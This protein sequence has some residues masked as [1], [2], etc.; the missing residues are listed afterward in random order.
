MSNKISLKKNFLYNFSLNIINILFPL[1]VSPYVSRIL[2]VSN[3][4]KYSFSLALINWFLIFATFGTTIYGIREISKVREDQKQLNK[5]FSE[6]FVINFITTFITLIVYLLII[7]SIYFNS[8]NKEVL[9]LLIF[10]LSIF[11]NLF[12]IDWLYMGLENFKTIALRSLLIK[13]ISLICIFLFI[14]ERNDY[15]LYALISILAFGFANILNLVYSK[16][17]VKLTLKNLSLKHHIRKLSVFFYSNLVISMYTIFDQ[18]LLGFLSTNRDVGYYSRAKQIYSVSLSVTLS[19]ST[20]LLPKLANLFKNDF[21]KYE[22]TLKKSINYIYIFSVPSVLG[23]IVLSKDIMWF[24]GGEEFEEA[25]ISLIILS[26]LVFTVSLSTWQYNQIFVP[27]GKE[28]IGLKSQI[29]M[30]VVSIL[31]NLLLIPLYG[32]IG[33][34]ISLLIAEISGTI[35]GVYYAKKKISEL[36]IQYITNS[37]IKYIFSS[38]IMATFIIIFKLFDFGYLINISFGIFFGA[39]IYFGILYFIKDEV[40]SLFINYVMAK[41]RILFNKIKFL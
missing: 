19:I 13:L 25:F 36:S 26:M 37:L 24:F 16:R 35:Y 39:I 32:Y 14:Q 31:S 1:L 40:C 20:V 12:C 41:F 15:I 38:M 18:V 30:A 9:L 5:T 17:F 2:G 8:N 28:V 21:R 22:V 4:G 29:F 10:A 6:I 27:F 11:L 33:A 3:I 7:I 23:L 34:S